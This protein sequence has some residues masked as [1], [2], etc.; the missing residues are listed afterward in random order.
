MGSFF[1]NVQNIITIF[2]RVRSLEN[3]QIQTNTS[4]CMQVFMYKPLF[5]MKYIKAK[6]FVSTYL[7]L[8]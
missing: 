7:W 4:V 6:R 8:P 5:K 3:T 1:N 2:T